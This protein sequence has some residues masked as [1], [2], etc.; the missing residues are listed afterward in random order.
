MYPGIRLGYLITSATLA[1]RFAAAKWMMDRHTSLLEQMAL[2]DFI[3]A[4]LLERHVRRMRRLYQQRRMALVSALDHHFG[5]AAEILGDQAGMHILVRFRNLE[6]ELDPTRDGV[7]LTSASKYYF[8]NAPANEYVM[9]FTAVTERALRE[10]VS[11]LQR[12]WSPRAKGA[13]RGD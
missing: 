11:R 3:E 8:S 1:H 2:A 9:G 5:E 4:G 7:R 6:R 12:A 13:R 10:G